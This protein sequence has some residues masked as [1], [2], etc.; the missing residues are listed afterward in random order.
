MPR[1]GVW[2]S[3]DRWDD[4]NLV[5]GPL[6][7]PTRRAMTPDNMSTLSMT[8]EDKAALTAAT[9][10]LAG[11]AAKYSANIPAAEKKQY[12]VIGTSRAGM[13]EVFLRSMADNPGLVPSYVVMGDV[14]ID[15]T[16]RAS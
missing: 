9:A 15:R 8:A 7:E 11:L 16:F 3:G 12:A 1:V 6:P 4:P 10:T 5:W 13:D 2:D 14:N